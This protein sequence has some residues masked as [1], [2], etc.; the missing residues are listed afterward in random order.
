MTS[1][2][3]LETLKAEITAIQ[4]KQQE[5]NNQSAELEKALRLTRDESLRLEGRL[6]EVKGIVEYLELKQQEATPETVEDAQGEGET[7]TSDA[8]GN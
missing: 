1:N 5:M 2:E 7:T 4:R 6:L 3:L 8:L